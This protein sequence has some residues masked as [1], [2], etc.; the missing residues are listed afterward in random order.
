MTRSL[1]DI[2]HPLHRLSLLSDPQEIEKLG[3]AFYLVRRQ[4]EADR[5]YRAKE[6]V[7]S[8]EVSDW[9][10]RQL[11]KEV[12]ALQI[13]EE[14]VRRFVVGDYHLEA[15]K[16]HRLAKLTL[17]EKLPLPYERKNLLLRALADPDE[18]LDTRK[19]E[20]QV[21]QV[22]LES[23]RL[24][25][26]YYRKPKQSASK[27]RWALGRSGEL[28]FSEDELI[29]LG[30]KIEFVLSDHELYIANLTSFENVFN[31]RDHIV[32]AREHNLSTILKMPFFADTPQADRERFKRDCESFFPTRRLAQMGE[33]QLEA[34]EH[35]F[36]E[37]CSDLR[38]IRNGI[39]GNAER[40]REYR[41]IYAPLWELY[42]FLDLEREQVK[43]PEGSH[44]TVLL[45]FFAD[46]IVR[47]FLTGDFGLA[48]AVENPED[49]DHV[50]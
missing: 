20:F 7:L 26:F 16:L 17:N 34:L 36:K 40:E 39:P 25:F 22:D 44:P 43:Y 49:A 45:R 29:E 35:H 13:E 37:R 4:K 32:Q 2:R 8:S 46:K 47:S 11:I 24:Y 6:F 30:G 33:P 12:Q 41:R 10:K 21:V 14:G 5:Y 38:M 3:L 48:D 15:N 27:K 19:T 23:S 9:F 31:Y 42:A 1:N 18:L 50:E 28:D